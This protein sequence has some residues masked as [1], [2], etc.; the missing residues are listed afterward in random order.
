VGLGGDFQGV[1]DAMHFQ[2]DLTPDELRQE[3]AGW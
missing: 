3:L 1:K 2:I